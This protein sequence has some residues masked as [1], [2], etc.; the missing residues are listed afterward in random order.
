LTQPTPRYAVTFRSQTPE[1]V[2]VALATFA[3]TLVALFF[4]YVIYAVG[5]TWESYSECSNQALAQVIWQGAGV[6]LALVMFVESFR[7]R[8]HPWLWFFLTVF[9]SGGGALFMYSET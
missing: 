5:C 1:T 8:G 9:V 3:G 4:A 7:E 6:I 2:L